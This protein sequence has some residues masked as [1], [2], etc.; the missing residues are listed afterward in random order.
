MIKNEDLKEGDIIFIAIPSF[1]Y[2]RVAKGTG[3]KASH[4]GI[5]LKDDAGNWVVAESAVPLSKY[6]TLNDFVNR[7]DKGWVCIRR[8]KEPISPEN[9]HEIKKQCDKR[10]GIFYHLGFK[11][12]S[13]RMF[14]SKFVYEVFKSVLDIEIGK[15]ETLKE[16]Y[17]KLPSTS[18]FFWRFW[19]FGFIPWN[20]V[21]VTPA[22]QMASSLLETVYES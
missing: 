1:L 5:I 19:Y 11:Y 2:R 3:S 7:T 13:K 15:L 21:T 4:V 10:M 8:F 14:C 22:S 6:S 17:S 12:H 16:L 18:L 20:R 9:I